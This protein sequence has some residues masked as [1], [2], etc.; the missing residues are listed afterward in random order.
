MKTALAFVLS[1]LSASALALEP[2]SQP[3][4]SE[5]S[6][7][8]RAWLAGDAV[9]AARLLESSTDR[10]SRLNRGVALLYAGDAS[11]AQRQLLSLVTSE[12]AWTPALSWLARAVSASGGAGLADTVERLL[13]TGDASSR[14]FLWAGRLALSS[15]EVELAAARLRTAVAREHDL[16]LGWLWLGDAEQALGRTAQARAAWRE[17]ERLHAGGEVLVR[18]GASHPPAPPAIALL[19]EPGE[20]LRY[21]AR[22]LFFR[23][24]TLEMVHQGFSVLNGRRVARVVVS[25]RSRPGFP[26]IRI[27]SRFESLIAD[28]GAVLAHRST[29]RDST[30]GRRS[31]AYEMNPD[32]GECRVRQVEDGLFGFDTLPL[33]PLGQDGLSIL[34]LARGVARLG[35]G[36]S[37]L[38]AVDSTWKGTELRAAG[39]KRVKWAGCDRDAVQVD[40]LGHYKG[41]AGLSGRV[42]AFFSPD[43]RALPYR[44]EIKLKLGSAVLELE[45]ARFAA[46]EEI[47]RCPSPAQ[48]APDRLTAGGEWTRNTGS[49]DPDEG[50][51]AAPAL[52]P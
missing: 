3:D 25:V 21:T 44:A 47:T 36:L 40:L 35:S 22:Y 32:T 46:R 51:R 48:H 45:P 17:A 31:A 28:D 7:V 37:V 11:G 5:E 41:P 13:R 14:D 8:V 4:T 43:A 26:L 6:P 27:D 1:L 42:K 29:S 12:P 49:S 24:A 15:G 39:R 34:Q 9:L 33:P 10:A 52:G 50:R 18:L 16:Y 30:Q 38:T 20:S 23:F 19:L 2:A